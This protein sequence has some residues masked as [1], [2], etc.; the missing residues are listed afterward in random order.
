VIFDCCKWDGDLCPFPLIL[1]AEAWHEVCSLALALARETTEAET[2]LQGC[3]E[4]HQ[5][6]GLPSELRQA[7]AAGANARPA[8]ASVRV[9]RFD[10][11]WTEEGW[12]ISEA[13]TDVASGFIE[14][15]GFT[16]LMRSHYPGYDRC[17]D[18][19]G[20]LADQVVARAGS[21]A[22][23]GLMHLTVYSE[24][25]QV[26][27]YLAQRFAE[28]GLQTQLFCPTQLR[29]QDQAAAIDTQWFQGQVDCLHRFVPAEWIA[30]M[31]VE[32]GWPGLARSGLTPVCNP[33]FVVLTQSKRFP[34]VWDRLGLPLP[35][36][37]CLLPETRALHEIAW[38]ETDQWLVKPAL[39]HEGI[40]IGLPGVTSQADWAEIEDGL[41]VA[42]EQWV[43]QRVF[44]TIPLATP[45]GTMYPC[46]GV[47]VIGNAVAG[48]YGR[49]STG[50]IVDDS[51]WDVAVLV[52][53]R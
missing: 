2:R 24:D 32:T 43:V 35:T 51:S 25:R 39:G 4:L 45:L 11:H 8:E 33:L 46:L 50:P 49:L 38:R 14:A 42:P 13:N 27:L 30:Q 28:R 19:A 47:Y 31:P 23:V 10:F 9:A 21:Q 5:D 22:T 44:H 12:R 17:G 18:P 34:L 40:R 3:T 36:W 20:V 26:M 53:E 41:S 48:A 29:W 1:K 7:L 6:L 15:S 52:E 37:R 16:A